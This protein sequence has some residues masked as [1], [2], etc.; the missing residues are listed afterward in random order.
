MCWRCSAAGT[1]I[2]I[3]DRQGLASLR[4]TVKTTPVRSI[5]QQE[6]IFPFLESVVRPTTRDWILSFC[7]KYF[8]EKFLRKKI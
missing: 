4:L 8:S 2:S 7:D 6:L 1:A 3:D 5:L